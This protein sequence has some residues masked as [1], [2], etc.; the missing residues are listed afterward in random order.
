MAA[1][2]DAVCPYMKRITLAKVAT[3][4]ERMGPQ[5]TVPDAIAARARTAL[6]RMV[7]LA[8]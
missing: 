4:L 3:C 5:V 6:E 2:E 8:A 7:A 1:S